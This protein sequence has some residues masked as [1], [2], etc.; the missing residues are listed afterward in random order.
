MITMTYVEQRYVD[1]VSKYRLI[2]IELKFDADYIAKSVANL[3]QRLR[4][5]D[6]K[7]YGDNPVHFL[8]AGKR[9]TR[10][11]IRWA[12]E[13]APA[14]KARIQQMRK[15]YADKIE[16]HRESWPHATFFSFE[17]AHAAQ[18]R[19]SFSSHRKRF[20]I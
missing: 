20:Y 17:A 3:Q 10:T 15:A 12:I 19:I 6:F 11:Y 13:S 7:R 8:H 1:F 14:R 16:K 5:F 4:K 2:L 18:L 9:I